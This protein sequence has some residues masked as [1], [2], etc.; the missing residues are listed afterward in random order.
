M[1][2]KFENKERSSTLDLKILKTMKK[3]LQGSGK[4]LLLPNKNKIALKVKPNTSV[5]KKIVRSKSKPID[6]ITNYTNKKTNTQTILKVKHQ[7]ELF[8]ETGKIKQIVTAKT[9]NKIY[10]NNMETNLFNLISKATPTIKREIIQNSVSQIAS[11][12][13]TKFKTKSTTN[14]RVKD[15]HNNTSGRINSLTPRA[16]EPKIVNI[17]NNKLDEKQMPSKKFQMIKKT[18]PFE[19]NSK[20]KSYNFII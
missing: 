18:D 12:A 9:S 11:K 19:N 4:R 16:K 6:L 15:L 20:Q 17:N 3:D 5:D 1:K 13:L 10:N 8:K 14:L 2:P 7:N